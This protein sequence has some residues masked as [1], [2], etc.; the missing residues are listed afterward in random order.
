MSTWRS[1]PLRRHRDRPRTALV[2]CAALV[3]CL[4][5]NPPAFADC[6]FADLTGDDCEV[7]FADP[8]QKPFGSKALFT[9]FSAGEVDEIVEPGEYSVCV[10]LDG[11]ADAG[12][13]CV[14]GA[15]CA[16]SITLA[17]EVQPVDGALSLSEDPRGYAAQ[18]RARAVTPP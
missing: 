1:R 9:D 6:P 12:P 7:T 17:I 10:S 8:V 2:A 3:P 5:C 4:V 18:T 15:G 13:A 14:F 11:T 16:N